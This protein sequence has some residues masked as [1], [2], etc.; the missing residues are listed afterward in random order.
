MLTYD[1]VLRD[2]GTQPE[3]FKGVAVGRA[4]DY[5]EAVAADFRRNGYEP[6]G[7][8][9]IVGVK[10]LSHTRRPGGPAT[11]VLRTC[12]D[13]R[14][15]SGRK[16]DGTPLEPAVKIPDLLQYTVTVTSST[17]GVHSSWRVQK[18]ANNPLRPCSN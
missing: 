14:T 9:T 15:T 2:G 18:L 8:S 16:R 12:E 17:P 6:V 13:T 10:M 11:V 7:A 3:R 5:M 1:E 4:R